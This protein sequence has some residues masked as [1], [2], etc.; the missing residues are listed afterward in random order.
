VRLVDPSLIQIIGDF[1]GNNISI[2]LKMFL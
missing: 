1:G 2:V